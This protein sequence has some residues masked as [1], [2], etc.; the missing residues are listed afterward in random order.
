MPVS[1]SSALQLLVGPR[2]FCQPALEEEHHH[3]LAQ[4]AEG[5]VSATWLDHATTAWAYTWGRASEEALGKA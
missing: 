2:E 1:H 4:G 3:G 5:H